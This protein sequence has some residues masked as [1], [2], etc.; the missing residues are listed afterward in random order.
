MITVFFGES[1]D[2]YLSQ[3]SEIVVWVFD[4]CHVA[5]VEFR[6]T[7]S[8][9]SRQLGY[10]G[11]FDKNYPARRNCSDSYDSTVSFSID[12]PSGERL[13]SIEVQTKGTYVVGLKVFI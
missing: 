5:G 13:S 4:I 1:D 12:D 9:Y 6:F 3:L 10:V 11:L 2:R 8:S 7:D